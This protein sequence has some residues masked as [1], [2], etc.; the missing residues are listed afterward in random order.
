[1]DTLASFSA[2]LKAV[3]WKAAQS[4][5]LTCNSPGH[6]TLLTSSRC[7][8]SLTFNTQIHDMIS[9]NGTIVHHNIPCPQGYCI[10]LKQSMTISHDRAEK[11]WS[12]DL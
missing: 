9:T 10:P 11:I 6:S 7:L 3:K 5:Q 1:M 8:V 2:I 4:V 12:S